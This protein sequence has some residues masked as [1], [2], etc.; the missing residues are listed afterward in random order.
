MAFHPAYPSCLLSGS[1][2][3]LVNI[4]DIRITDEDDA[5]SQVIN[6]GA[7]IAH[8]GFLTNTKIHALSHD[9]MLSIYHLNQATDNIDD[10]EDPPPIVFG[11]LRPKSVCEYVVNVLPFGEGAIVGAGT[12]RFDQQIA[13]ELERVTKSRISE[14]RLDLIALSSAS[15][16]AIDE[17]QTIRLAG[18]LGEEIVRSFYIDSRVRLP[19]VVR[20]ATL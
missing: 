9:E 7:S 3:G 18:A 12:H 20:K 17:S 5:L 2:D 10:R 15:G 19:V 6:H 14:H 4:Y 8:A 1:T 13:H 16:W 11:D